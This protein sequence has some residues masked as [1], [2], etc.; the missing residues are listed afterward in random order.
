MPAFPGLSIAFEDKSPYSTLHIHAKSADQLLAFREI[1]R[2]LATAAASMEVVDTH[3]G[4]LE[5]PLESLVLTTDA[6]E[7]W[8]ETRTNVQAGTL[9]VLHQR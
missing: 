9:S 1:F 2:R 6:E 3:F 7:S 5:P 8:I 4:D